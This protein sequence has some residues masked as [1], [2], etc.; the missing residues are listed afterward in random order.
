MQSKAAEKLQTIKR[1]KEMTK[2]GKMHRDIPM[3]CENCSTEGKYNE[4][5]DAY[6][7]K[8]CDAWSEKK[9]SDTNCFFCHRRPEK[10]SDV[11][12]IDWKRNL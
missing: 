2:Q 12:K 4:R 3:F 5:W 1:R 6:Y 10:P 7:C 9:C 8:K 11:K